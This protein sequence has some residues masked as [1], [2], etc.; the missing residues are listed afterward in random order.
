LKNQAETKKTKNKPIEFMCEELKSLR[1][2]MDAVALPLEKENLR[3]YT[4][5]Q[6]YDEITKVNNHPLS[7][8][9]VMGCFWAGLVQS[10]CVYGWSG[11]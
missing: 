1:L 3:N 7:L 10:A 11:C 8:S 2:G 5:Q 9:L 6:H 4:E